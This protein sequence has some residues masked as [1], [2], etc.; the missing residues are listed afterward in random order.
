MNERKKRL[1]DNLNRTL[2][3]PEEGIIK[4]RF[5]DTTGGVIKEG[6]ALFDI[7]PIKDKLVILSKLSVD[8]IGYI[9]KDKKW[10]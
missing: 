9:K 8:Q 2:V 3:T 1:E 4:Q 6:E 7:V 10:W 5:I